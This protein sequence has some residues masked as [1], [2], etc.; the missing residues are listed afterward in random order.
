MS[1]W[2]AAEVRRG[3]LAVEDTDFAAE[4]F[5][6]LCQTRLAIRYRLYLQAEPDEAEIDE[7]VRGAVTTFLARYG[8]PA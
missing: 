7:V 1:D 2:V 8:A 3:R 4:Q 6:A 5:F